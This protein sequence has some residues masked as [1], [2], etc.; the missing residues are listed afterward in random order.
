MHY[1]SLIHIGR[2]LG[3]SV[4]SSSFCFCSIRSAPL[5]CMLHCCGIG[6]LILCLFLCLADVSFPPLFLCIYL[7]SVAIR[8]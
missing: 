6:P 2:Q 7:L 5:S 3:L 8:F 4:L 1:S